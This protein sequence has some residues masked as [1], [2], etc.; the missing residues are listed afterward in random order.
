V[1]DFSPLEKKKR[2]RF[3]PTTWFRSNP[4]NAWQLACSVVE[5]ERFG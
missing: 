2:R 5:K 3:C 1:S 4:K